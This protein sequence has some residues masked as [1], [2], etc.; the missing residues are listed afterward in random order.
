MGGF[1]GGFLGWVW[2]SVFFGMGLEECVFGMGLE[3]SCC[4]LGWLLVFLWIL[5]GFGDV[6]LA[7]CGDLS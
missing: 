6:L 7:G 5:G 4:F 2:K 3:C 1:L